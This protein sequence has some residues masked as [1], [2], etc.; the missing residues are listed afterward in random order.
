[1]RI[2][3]HVDGDWKALGPA[4]PLYKQ[5]RGAGRR[6]YAVQCD[7]VN[8]VITGVVAGRKKRHVLPL[9]L[10]KRGGKWTNN[11]QRK[12]RYRVIGLEPDL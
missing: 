11:F 3:V 5:Q 4:R 6:C 12:E 2:E 8:V 7:D 9:V 10:I 1:M